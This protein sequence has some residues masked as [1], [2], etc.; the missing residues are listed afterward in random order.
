MFLAEVATGKPFPVTV[1]SSNVQR[2][3]K[4]MPG[5]DST[6]ALGRAA[7]PPQGDVSFDLGG[8]R[9][10]ALAV[11]APAVRGKDQAAA[12][13]SSFLNDEIVVYDEAQVKLRYC[14]RIQM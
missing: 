11:A 7:P 3:R 5:Y 10:A 4:A 6:L 12:E 8:G 14:V 9:A 1:D 13:E 2:L